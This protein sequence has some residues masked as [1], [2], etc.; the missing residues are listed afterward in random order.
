MAQ[1]NKTRKA[2]II[3]NSAGSK[4]ASSY[5]VTPKRTSAAASSYTPKKKTTVKKSA[6]SAGASRKSS[7]S[8]T[9]RRRNGGGSGGGSWFKRLFKWA[10]VAALWLGIII[11]GILAWYATELPDITK[12]AA[13]ERQSAITVLAENGDV[14][15]R[16]GEIKGNTLGI[17]DMP[18]HLINA[19][20]ATEDRRFYH[21]FGI[22]LI[23]LFRAFAVNIQ[24]GGVVQGGS[25]ITQQ[26]AKNLFLSHE[27]TY[28]RKIQEAMLAIWLE[29]QLTKDEILSAYLNRVY[30]GSGTYGVDAAAMLYFDKDAKDLTLRESAV[31]AGLLK[32]PSR[33]S[34]R[35]NP[36]LANERANVV[37]QAM[38]EAGYISTEEAKGLSNAPPRPPEKP[39]N[40]NGVRY[41][42]DWVVDGLDDL[43]GTPDTDL[44]IETTLVSN[45]QSMAEKAI[46]EIL[47]AEA[48]EKNI[49]QGAMVVMAHDGAILALVGGRDYN[50][51]QFNR[52]TQA[53]RQPGSSFKP[54]VY[55]TALE[56]GWTPDTLVM[57]EPITEGRYRPSNF[58]NKYYGEVNLDTA[59]TYSLNTTSYNIA[60]LF[61]P[62]AIIETARRL[63]IISPL[64]P[65]LSLALGSYAV[66]PLELTTSYAVIA[67]GGYSVF[68]YAITKIKGEDGT[69]YYERP[70]QTMTRRV[71]EQRPVMQLQMMMQNVVQ[72][73]TGQNAKM[74]FAVGGKTG[75]SQ[76]SRDAWFAGYTDRLVA[77]AWVGND[78]N[79]PTKA[80]TGGSVPA[81]IWARVIGS[82]QGSFNAKTT[83]PLADQSMIASMEYNGG[84]DTNYADDSGFQGILGRILGGGSTHSGGNVTRNA[85]TP[86]PRTNDSY[87]PAPDQ[88]HESNRR[89]NN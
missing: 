63:G 50:K 38:V 55:L 84:Y 62:D 88:N 48:A 87:E 49:E 6:K 7:R 27:R 16:Y 8:N 35:R 17:E 32:A 82:A 70:A 28:K 86:L 23:G 68:P 81:R 65:D 18:Q 40:A 75:T 45:I 80:V 15:A 11:A 33:Y 57:D 67:N 36:N 72:Y 69:V 71:V 77:A 89:Y 64:E 41:Y 58:G 14:L 44:I 74:G 51:S 26:L 54:I 78:D 31:I 29:H 37:L 21:H 76:D 85:V 42:T 12:S 52:I 56:K 53:K 59:L 22:D 39:G 47:N 24:A 1:H 13:F 83:A 66:S 5:P 20:I 10:F 73:G 34:P 30:L 25:T 46:F 79:S 19:V 43:I 60:K 4:S 2:P 9:P 3:S 61:G